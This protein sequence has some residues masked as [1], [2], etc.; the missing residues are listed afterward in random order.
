MQAQFFE[1]AVATINVISKLVKCMNLLVHCMQRLYLG[2]ASLQGAIRLVAFMENQIEYFRIFTD[3]QREK[4]DGF[5]GLGSAE[6]IDSLD[7]LIEM[8]QEF[9]LTYIIDFD[10]TLSKILLLYDITYSVNIKKI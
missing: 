9:V 5:I 8:L 6:S 7:N 10:L 1:Q 2:S 3:C 4:L